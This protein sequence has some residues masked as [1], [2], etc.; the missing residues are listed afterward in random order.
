VLDSC[1]Y[2][3]ESQHLPEPVGFW[4]VGRARD[5]SSLDGL[6]GGETAVCCSSGLRFVL[7]HIES[8][9]ADLVVQVSLGIIRK[10]F[11]WNH[12][13]VTPPGILTAWHELFHLSVRFV[14]VIVASRAFHIPLHCARFAWKSLLE[15][16]RGNEGRRLR[17]LGPTH[18]A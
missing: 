18:P 1:A 11:S 14:D 10:F 8:V 12:Y 5:G 2:L 16:T 4:V 15:D 3:R 7:N 17:L 6:R 13:P 9:S